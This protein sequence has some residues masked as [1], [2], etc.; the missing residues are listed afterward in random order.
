VLEDVADEIRADE[1]R[2]AGDDKG[3]YTAAPSGY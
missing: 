3:S 2:A 1:P